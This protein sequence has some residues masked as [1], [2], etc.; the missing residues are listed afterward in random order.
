MVLIN[1]TAYFSVYQLLQIKNRLDMLPTLI[2][3]QPFLMQGDELYFLYL[4]GKNTQHFGEALNEYKRQMDLLTMKY[5]KYSSDGK[6]GT[7]T[8]D[9]SDPTVMTAYTQECLALDKIQQPVTYNTIS[10]DDFRAFKIHASLTGSL[11]F[12]IDPNEIN[13]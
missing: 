10:A 12:L 8:I 4:V 6:Q 2:K 1:T 13:M 11:W 7:W 5:G 3:E 9:K